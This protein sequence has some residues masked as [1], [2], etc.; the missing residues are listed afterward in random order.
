MCNFRQ[1]YL[2][3][4]RSCSATGYEHSSYEGQST[5][6]RIIS[7]AATIVSLTSQ[8]PEPYKADTSVIKFYDPEPLLRLITAKRG[9]L[10]AELTLSTN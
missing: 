4:N 10:R 9:Q 6:T 5:Q 7:F 1:L 8:F 2:D 3:G